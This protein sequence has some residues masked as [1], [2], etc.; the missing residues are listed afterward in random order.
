[1]KHLPEILVL[2]LGLLVMG[3]LVYLVAASEGFL[4]LLGIISLTAVY[5]GW[6]GILMRWGWRL[7]GRDPDD[8]DFHFP[9]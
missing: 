2:V 7:A 3:V 9:G 5:F 1:M 4:Q 8:V 6:Q